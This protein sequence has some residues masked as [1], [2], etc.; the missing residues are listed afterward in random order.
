MSQVMEQSMLVSSPHSRSDL[1]YNPEI[2]LPCTKAE[3][4]GFGTICSIPLKS[5]FGSVCGVL[6]VAHVRED[7]FTASDEQVFT[8]ISIPMETKLT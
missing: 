2:D 8:T 1:R 5:I 7:A 3:T 4:K 6:Q